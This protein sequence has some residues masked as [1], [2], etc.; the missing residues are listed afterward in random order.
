MFAP[1][2]ASAEGNVGTFI[3]RCLHKREQKNA[4]IFEPCSSFYPSLSPLL[5]KESSSQNFFK[6]PWSSAYLSPQATGRRILAPPDS[7]RAD[8]IENPTGLTG[9][10]VDLE[11]YTEASEGHVPQGLGWTCGRGFGQVD[12][13]RNGGT[14]ESS[15]RL[16]L[17]R[18]NDQ[19]FPEEAQEGEEFYGADEFL[20]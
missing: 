14:R 17:L 9:T 15:D 18:P 19:F 16:A 7:S 13:I 1:V 4:C 6:L 12:M 8:R 10:E 5:R 11:G 2:P 3:F 20:F